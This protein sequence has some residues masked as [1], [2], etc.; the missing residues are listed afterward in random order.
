[1]E[2]LTVMTP[3]L[4]DDE[5]VQWLNALRLGE[6]EL[7][8]AR[9]AARGTRAKSRLCGACMTGSKEGWGGTDS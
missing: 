2:T 7:S 3:Y 1:M 5:R 9:R 8:D 4:P 6:I